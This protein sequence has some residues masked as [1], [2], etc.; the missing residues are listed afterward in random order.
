VR[1]AHA[2]DR[3]PKQA[4][5]RAPYQRSLQLMSCR[6]I[7]RMVDRDLFSLHRARALRQGRG[8]GTRARAMDRDPHTGWNS[9]SAMRF[10][11]SQARRPPDQRHQELRGIQLVYLA[12]EGALRRM[13]D[14]AWLQGSFRVLFGE[15]RPLYMCPRTSGAPGLL[16]TASSTW[17]L[18]AEAAASE[19]PRGVRTDECCC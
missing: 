12:A 10:R 13:T 18:E 11:R 7:K 15:R 2:P 4:P 16:S 8:A 9:Y 14:D 3:T 5:P 1:A 19:N 6:N 17:R